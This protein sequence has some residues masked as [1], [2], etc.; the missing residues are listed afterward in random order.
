VGTGCDMLMIEDALSGEPLQ[1]A[2]RLFQ[3]YAASLDVDLCFQGFDRELETLPGSYAPPAGRLLVAQQNGELAG[4]VALRP[5]EPGICEMKRLYVRPAFRGSGLGRIL[6]DRII[7]EARATGYARM[8]LD[9]LPSMIPA[10][11]LYRRLGFRDIPSYGKNPVDGAVFLELPL[12]TG[13]Q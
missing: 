7:G 13:A 4:C 1:Q 5:L 6:V 8:R 3:E 12:G 9:S 10:I 11:A 2:R